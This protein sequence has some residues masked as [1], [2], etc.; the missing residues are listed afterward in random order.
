MQLWFV[1]VVVSVV[2]GMMVAVATVV[3]VKAATYIIVSEYW[4]WCP[5]AKPAWGDSVFVVVSD[6]LQWVLSLL[7]DTCFFI[8]LFN[9]LLVCSLFLFQLWPSAV[10][11]YAI[12]FSFFTLFVVRVCQWQFLI[13]KLL[14]YILDSRSTLISSKD[15]NLLKPCEHCAWSLC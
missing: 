6:A 2:I 15:W 11:L 8:F 9:D 13:S 14:C 3:V 7:F 12:F 4:E 10:P 5:F 1:I